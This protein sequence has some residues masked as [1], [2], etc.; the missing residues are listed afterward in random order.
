MSLFKTT[1]W[2]AS[3]ALIL[4]PLSSF[5][6]GVYKDDFK[7]ADSKELGQNWSGAFL[8]P[9][10]SIRSNTAVPEKAGTAGA[11]YCNLAKADHSPK[12]TVV[13]EFRAT[14]LLENVGK[15]ALWLGI[16]YDGAGSRE[17]TDFILIQ[18]NVGAKFWVDGAWRDTTPLS[19]ALV[20][21]SWYRMTLEQDG[22]EFSATVSELDGTVLQHNTYTSSAKSSSTGYAYVFQGA[23]PGPGVSSTAFD[24]FSLETVPNPQN[25]LSRIEPLDINKRGQIIL[26]SEDKPRAGIILSDNATTKQMD[27]ATRLQDYIDRM[28]G[29]WLPI[30]TLSEAKDISTRILVGPQAAKTV[31]IDI[32]QTYPGG[33]RV[34][35]KTVGSDIVIAGNDAGAY[36][37]T[38][39]AVDQFLEDLGC[40]WF[41]PNSHWI[42]VP[43]LKDIAVGK[44]D[45][46]T[47]PVFKIRSAFLWQYNIVHGRGIPDFDLDIWGMVGV[48]LHATHNY[49][50]IFPSKEYSATHPEYYALVGGKR[51]PDSAQLCFS[52]PEVVAI[53]VETARKHF[54]NDPNQVM[55]SLSCNDCG[56]F[57]ECE[58]C[59]KL[60]KRPSEQTLW[61]TNRVVTE[62]RKTHPDKCVIFIGYWFTHVAPSHGKAL[63][64]V[65][66]MPVNGSCKAHGLSNKSCPSKQM[67][68]DNFKKWKATGA[69]L[70]IYEWYLPSLGGWKNIPWILGDASLR[71]LRFYRDNGVEGL[72]YEGHS[73]ETI[74]DAPLRWP[75][76]Y[77]VAKGMWNPDLTATQILEPA[78]TKLF[79]KAAK[80]MLDFYLEC[81]DAIE[82]TPLHAGNWGLPNPRGVYTAKVMAKLNG[83]LTEAM[84]KAEGGPAE[85]TQRIKDTMDCWEKAEKTINAFDP[86]AIYEVRTPAGIWYSVK[87][88]VDAQYLS[89]LV[90]IDQ[91]YLVE[92]DGSSRKLRK[93]EKLKL[94]SAKPIT[95]NAGY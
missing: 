84:Q 61:F 90:G 19:K 95:V 12:A 16:N 67:W 7:R 71:D 70:S 41:G 28:T 3:L 20:L 73:D 60:G 31:G 65:I 29:V 56:G 58:N 48:V 5:A 6:A 45:I 52:N 77:I 62:L 27:A 10:L 37:N 26:V 22:A 89:E 86:V 35:V 13:V 11:A 47:S 93:D 59:R 36:M 50:K 38:R 63:P 92:E 4:A 24:N 82:K 15:P 39:Y 55:F 85:M 9:E 49:N 75:L 43:E 91:V 87:E 88:E 80:P 1:L 81:A 18:G 33:E 21:G 17:T 72:F 44:L 46:N 94:D 51:V 25:S 66:I 2:A 54:D 83:F 76:I 57:C 69:E 42:V 78:C 32:P 14:H 30:G 8:T 23:A 68:I 79:G 53:T 40:G 64:G 74:E 34:I